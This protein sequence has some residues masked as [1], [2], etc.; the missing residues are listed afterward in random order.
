MTKILLVEDEASLRHGIQLNL[1]AEGMSVHPFE[2]A[3]NAL[4]Y[5]RCDPSFSMAI[6]DIMMHGSLN[7]LDLCRHLRQDGLSFPVL[8]LTAKGNL[9]DKLEGFK[10]GGDDYL[11]KPF[12]LEELLARV[13][14]ILRRAPAAQDTISLGS[15]SVDIESGIARDESGSTVRFNEREKKILKLLIENRGR[16][17]S[18]DQILDRVWGT[19]EFPTNRTVDNFIVKFRK[20]FEEDAGNPSHFITRHGL[21]YELSEEKDRKKH[22]N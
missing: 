10:V 18:R 1:E 13:Y 4:S 7:G 5:I 8:F 3:D 15:F 6:F 16:P 14:A 19:A 9:E 17:V 2:N 20:I 22:G 21:G 11:T 12:D